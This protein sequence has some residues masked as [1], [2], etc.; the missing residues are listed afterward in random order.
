M[1]FTTALLRLTPSNRKAATSSSRDYDFPV[2][3]GIPAEETEK[4]DVRLRKE[5]CVAIRCHAYDRTVL[6]F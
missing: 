2:V 4:V 1:K 5:T 3:L 6:P